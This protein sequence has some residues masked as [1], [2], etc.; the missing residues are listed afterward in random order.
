MSVVELKRD[1]L[2]GIFDTRRFVTQA[3]EKRD[4][5]DPPCRLRNV[6]H[7]IVEPG[8]LGYAVVIGDIGIFILD[9]GSEQSRQRRV[10][11][12]GIVAASL[13][14]PVLI[15]LR[16]I[17]RSRNRDPSECAR[18]PIVQ[19]LSAQAAARRLLSTGPTARCLRRTQHTRCDHLQARSSSSGQLATH[20]PRRS[21]ACQSPGEKRVRRVHRA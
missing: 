20:L 19:R 2:S 4:V 13:E 7:F 10:M 11:V 18:T 3:L 5:A 15:V 9:G 6:R 1:T 21:S 16:K 12:Q 17:S 8:T 14:N